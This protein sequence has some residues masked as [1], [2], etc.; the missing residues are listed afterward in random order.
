MGELYNS[1][2]KV[3]PEF[4][5][6]KRN[7][8]TDLLCIGMTMAGESEKCASFARLPKSSRASSGLG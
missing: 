1:A 7:T 2:Q 4:Q 3:I 5:K 8:R 6:F